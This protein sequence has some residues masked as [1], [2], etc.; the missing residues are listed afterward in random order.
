MTASTKE[1]DGCIGFNF[2]EDPTEKGKFVFIEKFKDEDDN[3]YH[4][5]TSHFKTFVTGLSDFLSEPLK[6]EAYDASKRG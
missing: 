2:Y 4:T 3:K 1:E 5:Q 6:A